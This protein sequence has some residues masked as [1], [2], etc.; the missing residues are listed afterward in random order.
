MHDA[1]TNWKNVVRETI[2]RGMMT[3]AGDAVPVL[4]MTITDDAV[5]PRQAK[6]LSA[7]LSETL[8]KTVGIVLPSGHG[9]AIGGGWIPQLHGGPSSVIRAFSPTRDFEWR[10]FWTTMAASPSHRPKQSHCQI[11]LISQPCRRCHS[12]RDRVT[13]CHQS[14]TNDHEQRGPT[15]MAGRA[16]PSVNAGGQVAL[17]R[18]LEIERP[19]SWLYYFPFLHSFYKQESNASL[20]GRPWIDLYL[21]PQ[22]SGWF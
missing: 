21:P 18:S 14:P 20:G 13:N 19:S 10:S 12:G 15:K 7:S 9:A 16:T 11:S 3:D 4:R 17:Q 5:P 2:L 6:Q 1:A 8:G 22:E